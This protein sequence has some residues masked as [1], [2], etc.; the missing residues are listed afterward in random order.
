[1]ADLLRDIPLANGLTVSISD[2]THRYYGDFYRVRVEFSCSAPLREAYFTDGQTFG[3]ARRL[4]GDMVTYRRIVEQMGVPSTE[5]ERVREKLV[6]NFIDH[7]LP[8][9]T[10]D[11]FPEK[12]VHGELRKIS[13]KGGRTAL[14]PSKNDA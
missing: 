7:S 1:M 2:H 10:A 3:E 12:L 4:L 9:F 8:Y 13:R 5:I 6:Q 11:D 14:P